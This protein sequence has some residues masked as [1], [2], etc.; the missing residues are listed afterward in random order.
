MASSTRSPHFILVAAVSFSPASA[1]AMT[2]ADTR[3]AAAG[4]GEEKAAAAFTVEA[5]SDCATA[6]VP[7]ETSTRASAVANPSPRRARRWCKRCRPRSRRPFTE[8]GVQPSWRAASSWEIPCRQQ[9]TTG[10][11][12]ASGRRCTSSS[13]IRSASRAVN[14]ASG[15]GR[16]SAWAK[17][18]PRLSQRRR[19]AAVRAPRATW[20]ATPC[21][22]L[23]RQPLG[24]TPPALRARTRKVAWKA[25]SASCR[26]PRTCR[27]TRSTIGPWR[28]TSASNAAG[29]R[30]LRKR[31]NS[32]ESLV[33]EPAWE[34]VRRTQWRR[35]SAWVGIGTVLAGGRQKGAGHLP[36]TA[37][38]R[39]EPHAEFTRC[40]ALHPARTTAAT[41][42]LRVD[43]GGGSP[44]QTFFAPR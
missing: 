24:P 32:P 10:R 4:P 12:Y 34:M 36:Y 33:S 37:R 1:S 11:R 6:A 44:R 19:R 41:W 2:G 8:P 5:V 31:A 20:Y 26:L 7:P 38:D 22:Q 23:A 42:P 14:S 43:P 9:R 27:H 16:G 3:P 18:G 21:S 25:S 28:D 40:S 29:S 15:S 13:R 17:S 39:A 30:P 35:R